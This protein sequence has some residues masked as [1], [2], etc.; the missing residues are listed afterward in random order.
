M[1]IIITL[2]NAGAMQ[3]GWKQ[4]DGSGTISKLMVLC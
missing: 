3:T 4:L 1:V 2:M